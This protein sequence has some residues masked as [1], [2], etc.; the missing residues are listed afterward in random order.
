M[1]D[2]GMHW[3]DVVILAGVGA[4]LMMPATLSIIS[5]TFHARERGMAIGIW[6][7]VSAMALAIDIAAASTE[8][9]GWQCDSDRQKASR[10][11][12]SASSISP[13]PSEKASASVPPGRTGNS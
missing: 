4:A 2:F 9:P 11:S 12:R 7:G 5:A 1:S 6:A 3:L 8:T 10:P 13:N